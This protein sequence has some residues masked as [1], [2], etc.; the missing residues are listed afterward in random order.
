MEVFVSSLYQMSPP[1]FALVR[2][3]AASFE[4]A[5]AES[6]PLTPIDVGLA[7]RQHAAY[8]DALRALVGEVL[9]VAAA[10][11]CPDCCFIEDTVVVVGRQ[12]LITRP[13]APSRRTE[14]RGVETTLRHLQTRGEPLAIKHLSEAARLDGGDVLFVGGRLFVGLSQRTNHVAVTEMQASLDCPVYAVDVREGLHLKS[15]LSALDDQTLIV[16]ERP[17]AK[18]LAVQIAT[19]MGDKLE[20]VPVPDGPAANVL[21]LGRS[22]LIQAGFARSAPILEAVCAG[23][24]LKVQS[25]TMSEFIKADGALTCCSVIIP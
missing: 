19:I 18:A 16:A 25:L 4:R 23:R 8:V 24:G 12:A 5:L 15:A 22:V 17:A 3:L 21:R 1:R 20:I 10:D 11:D 14:T 9:E 2:P 7:R 13:G 6:P